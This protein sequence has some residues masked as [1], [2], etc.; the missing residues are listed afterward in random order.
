M[1]EAIK[2][3]SVRYLF[4]LEVKRPEDQ[5]GQH[6]PVVSAASAAATAVAAPAAATARKEPAAAAAPAEEPDLL[7]LEAPARPTAL[8]YSA[9]ALDGNPTSGPIV[10]SASDEAEGQNRE[11]RRA[12]ARAKK[13][14]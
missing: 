13:H 5:A 1:N 12:A 8:S 6:A 3:E 14:H 11:A 2:E 4:N 9:S 7:G 10:T